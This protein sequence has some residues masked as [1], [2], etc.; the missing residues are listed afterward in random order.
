METSRDNGGKVRYNM[1]SSGHVH[2]KATLILMKTVPVQSG[3]G[4]EEASLLEVKHWSFSS[5]TFILLSEL[6]QF[7][8]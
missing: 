5:Q 6:P 1:E 8:S 3:C 4:T 2:S 7:S